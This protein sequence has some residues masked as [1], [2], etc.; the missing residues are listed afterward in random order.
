MFYIGLNK[1][2]CKNFLSESSR[3][4]RSP[5]IWHVASHSR[6][7]QVFLNYARGAKNGPVQGFTY[8]TY[9]KPYMGKT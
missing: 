3:P 2:T 9:Y 7:L 4:A 1:E 6:L 5:D 8:F